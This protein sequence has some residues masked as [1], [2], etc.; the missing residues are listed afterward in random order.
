P[1]PP[2]SCGRSAAGRAALAADR[3]VGA[4]A[5]RPR[6]CLLLE[7]ACKLVARAGVIQVRDRHDA[8]LTPGAA[9]DEQAGVAFVQA[10]HPPDAAVRKQRAHDVLGALQG[11]G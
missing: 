11:C 10:E 1:L 3:Q 8:L 2:A 5:V 4:D 9:P 6:T 7:A